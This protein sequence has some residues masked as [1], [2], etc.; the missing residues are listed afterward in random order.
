MQ[1][2]KSAC[3]RA[4]A[5]H[6]KSH[7]NQKPVHCN[8]SVAPLAA[9]KSLHSNEDPAQPE[10]NN[11]ILKIHLKKKLNLSSHTR[12]CMRVSEKVHKKVNRGN[13]WG[14]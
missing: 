12:T 13:L 5:P 6:K 14:V 1:P 4:C 2:L 11:K 3:S 8:R 7:S 10:I 9:T